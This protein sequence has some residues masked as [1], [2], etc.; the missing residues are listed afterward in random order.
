MGNIE[1]EVD[2]RTWTEELAGM[3]IVS[4]RGGELAAFAE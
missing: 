4:G 2:G 3:G 1:L